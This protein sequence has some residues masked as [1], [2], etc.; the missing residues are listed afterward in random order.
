[1]LKRIKYLGNSKKLEDDKK[2][3]KVSD[4]DYKQ[5]IQSSRDQFA[6]VELNNLS[7]LLL[8]FNTI[9]KLNKQ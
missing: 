2:E 1:M 9:I 5:I 7:N 3:D 6:F 4:E 8:D